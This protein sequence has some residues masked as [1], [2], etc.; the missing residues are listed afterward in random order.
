[1][2]AA[3]PAAA[4]NARQKLLTLNITSLP[5]D[6]LHESTSVTVANVSARDR[7]PL[8]PVSRRADGEDPTS[9]REAR[10]EGTSGEEEEDVSNVLVEVLCLLAGRPSRLAR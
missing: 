5:I 6:D 9:S 8:E 2:Y 1:V 7:F 4:T 10:S 3:N